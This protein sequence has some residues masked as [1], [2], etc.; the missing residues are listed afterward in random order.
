MTPKEKAIFLVA[1]F[2]SIS[3]P[4]INCDRQFAK[5]CAKRMVIQLNSDILVGVDLPS[6]YGNYWEIVYN[7]IENL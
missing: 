6:T 5:E 2:E 7:E 4:L 1:L 3:H